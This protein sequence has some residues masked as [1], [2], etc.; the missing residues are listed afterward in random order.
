M[1]EP[2]W[3]AH[4]RHRA[5]TPAVT[6]LGRGRFLLCR[7][8]SGRASGE[9]FALS[10]P[11]ESRR[12]G[13][14]PALPRRDGCVGRL[15]RRRGRALGERG[16]KRS[17]ASARRV[18]SRRRHRARARRCER[19]RDQPLSPCDRRGRGRRSGRRGLRRDLSSRRTR[20]RPSA[21]GGSPAYLRCV[22]RLGHLAQRR[23]PVPLGRLG[24]RCDGRV[25]FAGRR[26][27]SDP[28]RR[29]ASAPRP[30]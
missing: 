7:P 23:E 13:R 26:R 2:G 24:R 22:G 6:S 12:D 1:G 21:C 15:G 29:L 20:S 19:G 27:E 18:V 30:R 9:R 11:L 14:R 28:A 16:P 5:P 8:D 3:L 25:L 17:N 4:V 10:A